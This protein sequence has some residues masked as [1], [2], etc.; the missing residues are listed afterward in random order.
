MNQACELIACE[1]ASR[2]ENHPQEVAITG[3]GIQDRGL[4]YGEACFETMRVVEGRIFAWEAHL[5][6]LRRGLAAFELTC[7]EDLLPRCLAAAEGVGDDDALL[8]LT[9]SGGEAQRGLLV[10][11]ERQA[12][13]HIQAWA[14]RPVSHA[15]E[16]RTVAWPLTGLSRV[17]KF[18]ADYAYTIRL[19]HQARRGGLLGEAESALFTL[20]G[21]LLCMETANIL[22]LVNGQWCTPDSEMVLPGVVRGALL[23]AGVVYA[24]RCPT[25]WLQA[26]EAMAV[27]NSGYFLRPVSR[28]NGRRLDTHAAHFSPLVDAL[29]GQAGVP[30][31]LSCP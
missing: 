27:C 20:G 12:R 9:A 1:R 29:R 28:V 5:A 22:L 4:L 25:G 6:R 11:G 19:L 16:L 3:T 18:T 14:Y 7:P 24:R 21:D 13:V 8:R 17:A 15:F 30:E 2:K 26:C 23:E 31:G 10:P